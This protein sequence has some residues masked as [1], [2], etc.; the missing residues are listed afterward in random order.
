MFNVHVTQFLCT[1]S[2]M[3]TLMSSQVPIMGATQTPVQHK[4]IMLQLNVIIMWRVCYIY[5]VIN[6]G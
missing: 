1:D 6:Q 4:A 3:H 2:H 5:A